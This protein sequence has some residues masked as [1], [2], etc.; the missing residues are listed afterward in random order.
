MDLELSHTYACTMGAFGTTFKDLVRAISEWDVGAPQNERECRDLLACWLQE[1]LS[2][3]QI[4]KRLD[5]IV[6]CLCLVG[7][8]VEANSVLMVK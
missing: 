3:D 5:K 6:L 4:E 2:P 8:L 7:L 1:E